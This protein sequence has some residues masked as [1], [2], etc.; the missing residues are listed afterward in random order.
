MHL[1]LTLIAGLRI[2]PSVLALVIS[3]L[4]ATSVHGQPIVTNG[5]FESGLTGWTRADQTGSNGTFALQSGTISPVT[6]TTVPAPPG[7]TLAAMTDALGPG[8]HVLYQ[9]ITI[10]SAAVG[11]AQLSFSVFIGNRATAFSVPSPA[12]LDF[13]T[14]ALNQQAR[15]DIVS[16]AANPFSVTAADVLFSAYQTVVGDPLVSGY[17]TRT[18]DVT[19]LFNA[20]LGST[21]RLRF[22]ETD[23][24]NTFQLGVDN[25]TVTV[26]P[27]PE[28]SAIVLCG[29]GALGLWRGRRRKV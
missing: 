6:G 2:P 4:I 12:S 13:S 24:V 9:D 26:T 7:G 21:V 29:V 23:N 1:M 8:S 18:F 27:I 20:N 22:A 15:V 19:S 14:P 25:V 10:P 11:S 28:P 16:T 5:G 17:T 3:A